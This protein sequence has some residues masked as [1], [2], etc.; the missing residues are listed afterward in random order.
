VIGF[1][2]IDEVDAAAALA[3]LELRVPVAWLTPLPAGV[4]YRHDLVGCAVETRDGGSVGVVVDV[5]GSMTGSRLV[6]KTGRGET[7]VPLA[8]TI[9]TTID[10]HGKRIII[11]PP[12][13]LL[14][15]NERAERPGRAG[16]SG[17]SSRSDR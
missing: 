16:R 11:D 12:E 15:L 2:G 1:E 3:G 9:C 14:E 5:E 7:L 4:Y 6:V 17:G 13:G 8:D 10:P